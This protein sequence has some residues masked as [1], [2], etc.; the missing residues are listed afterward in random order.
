MSP[1]R[2]TSLTTVVGYLLALLLWSGVVYAAGAGAPGAA[3]LALYLLVAW[4]CA[5]IAAA[6][7]DH[8]S[9]KSRR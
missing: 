3:A 5:A 6:A 8:G 2:R 4:I 7:V 9:R 1:T